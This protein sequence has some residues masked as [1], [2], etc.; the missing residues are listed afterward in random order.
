M[1]M[2]DVYQP[3]CR[4]AKRQINLRTSAQARVKTLLLLTLSVGLPLMAVPAFTHE[5]QTFGDIGVTQ[6]IEPNDDPKAGEPNLVWFAL[7]HQGGQLIPLQDCQCRLALYA[8]PHPANDRPLQE[9]P[10]KSV[11][12]E[13]YSGVPGA[14][15]T[16]PKAGAYE[17]VFSGKPTKPNA[18]EPFTFKF[19]VAVAAGKSPEPSPAANTPAAESPATSSPFSTESAPAKSSSQSWIIALGILVVIGLIGS[20]VWGR[21]QGSK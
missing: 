3:N 7:T 1:T 11:N 10:L 5:V 8:S 4:Q 21:K 13:G 17:L 20:I 2:Q 6:H 12:S 9:P 19:E 18:F 14:D 15:V 16:F